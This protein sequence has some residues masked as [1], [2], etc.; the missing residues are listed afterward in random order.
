MESRF[1]DHNLFEL[2]GAHAALTVY[3]FDANE[4]PQNG[5]DFDWWIGNQATG[6]IGLRCQAKKLDDGAYAELGHTVRGERQYDVLLRESGAEGMWPLYCFYNGWDGGWPADVPNLAC[7]KGVAPVRLQEFGSKG[8]KHVAVEHFGCSLAPAQ[9]VR[10]RHRGSRHGRLALES[11]L[12]FSIPW[13]RLFAPA[14]TSAGGGREGM[15]VIRSIEG[16]LSELFET[17]DLADR[18][19]H[20]QKRL[21]SWVVAIRRGD[22]AEAKYAQKPRALAVL[23]VPVD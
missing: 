1:T 8:C 17:F 12:A 21:P 10:R 20:R 5:A 18:G 14:A 9:L 6:W 4:E 11:Y 7:P 3:K 2:D 19:G 16:Y 15:T 13:S 23:E 22:R